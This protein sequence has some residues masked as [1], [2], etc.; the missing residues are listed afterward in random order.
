MCS[1]VQEPYMSADI[2]REPEQHTA[3]HDSAGRIQ[4]KWS[5][6]GIMTTVMS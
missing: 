2:G 1:A 3:E 5:G 6:H 4:D